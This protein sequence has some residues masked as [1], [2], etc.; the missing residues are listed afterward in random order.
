MLGG[1]ESSFADFSRIGFDGLEDLPAQ[2]GVLLGETGPEII[3]QA[4]HVMSD[5]N[6]SVATG[7]CPDA[8][9]GDLDGRRDLL[10]HFGWHA[11]DDQGE[12]AGLLG[13]QC[14][15]QDLGLIAL[16]AKAAYTT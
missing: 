7:A 10:S 16:N 4:E 5:E 1:G 9:G 14:V 8:D 11:L 3:E 2:V 12:G 13:G 6:L 15:I